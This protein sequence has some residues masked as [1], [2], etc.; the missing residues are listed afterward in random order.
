MAKHNLIV[1]EQ[2]T[3]VAMID[4]D[5]SFMMEDAGKGVSFAQDDNI[6]PIIYLL[7]ANSP[8]TKKS[9]PSYVDGALPGDI[10]KRNSIHKPLVKGEEGMLFQ[11]CYFQKMW[12]EWR[13]NRGGLAGVHND[14][15]ADA[16][17]VE[18]MN[19]GKPKLV[20]VRDNGN[21]VVETRQHIGFAEG[22][23]FVIPF[24]STGHTVSR[25]WMQMMGQQYIPGTTKIA[26]AWAKVYRLTSVEKTKGTDSW[27][28]LKA[29][30]L[31][32]KG[33]VSKDQYMKG[34]LLHD[35]FAKGEKKAMVDEDIGEGSHNGNDG[36]PQ[37]EIPF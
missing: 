10:W 25:T 17:Q 31:G 33:W 11:H 21:H 24:S 13:P 37:E 12:I 27:F 34:K 8:A 22:E 16:K 26:P 9:N 15:P 28:V 2:S 18:I 30:D 3:E 7:Q 1:D 14:K 23:T 35:A 36:I 19:D 20:W 6:V 29:E 4:N 5:L 32:D